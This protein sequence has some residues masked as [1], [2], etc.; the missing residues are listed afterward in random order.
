MLLRMLVSTL[1]FL[2]TS[3]SDHLL[4]AGFSAAERSAPAVQEVFHEPDTARLVVAPREPEAEPQAQLSEFSLHPAYTLAA[5]AREA[6][7]YEKPDG[8]SRRLGYLKAGAR[9]TRSPS[10]I[11]R[12]GCAGG[13]YAVA[14]EGFVCVGSGA[15]LDLAHPVVRMVERGPDRHAALPYRYGL[16]RA[17]APPLYSR[18]P[19]ATEQRRFESALLNTAVLR[20]WAKAWSNA[21]VTEV[22]AVLAGGGAAPTPF[23]FIDDSRAL[24]QDMALSKSAFALVRLFEQGGR[25]FGITT[26]FE[27]VPVDRLKPVEPSS[28]AGLALS[29]EVSLPVAFVEVHYAYLYRGKPEAGFAPAR[30]LDYREAFALTDRRIGV[31]KA[32]F[33]QTSAGDWLRADQLRIIGLPRELPPR[34]DEGKTWLDVSLSQQSLIAF[35]GRKPVYVTLI[36]SGLNRTGEGR[37]GSATIQGEYLIH[38]KHVT[39]TMSSDEPGDS[40]DMREVPYVQY[41]S[42]GYALH[43]AFWH[44]GFGRPRSHGCINLSPLDARYLFTFTDPP[45]PRNWHGALSLNQGTLV[46]I[47]E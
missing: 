10:P 46:R 22:P 40:Y 9:V 3:L 37:G 15:T 12:R 24:V 8:N 7:V 38:A 39:A 47:H 28:F 25:R 5:T 4:F 30:R 44:D 19:T 29:D 18:I 1:V 35:E 34:A 23:G 31:G 6:Y 41:F 33:V 2:V 27:I 21:P 20:A 43:A 36:S 42:E 17:P 26:D 14:P 11:T 16:S 45:V 32:A 13:F